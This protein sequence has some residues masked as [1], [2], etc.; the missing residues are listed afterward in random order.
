MLKS[1]YKSL[2][3]IKARLSKESQALKK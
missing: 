2:I 3:T 1:G